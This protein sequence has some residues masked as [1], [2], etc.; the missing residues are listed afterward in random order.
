L[1]QHYTLARTERLAAIGEV[2]A[3]LAHEIRN[4]LAGIQMAFANFRREIQEP[5][6]VERLNMINAELKRLGLLLND[7]LDQSRHTPEVAVDFDVVSLI[8]DLATLTRYQLAEN[9]LLKIE[10]DQSLRLHLPESMLRQALLNLLLNAAGALEVQGG[11]IR[12]SVQSNENGLLI[13]V[14]DN[15]SGFPEEMLAYGIRP[16]RSSH[17]RGTG[18]GLAM[19]QRFVKNI[20]GSISLSNQQ[21]QGACVTMSLPK[22]CQLTL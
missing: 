22:A 10:A 12:I 21:P 11:E 20:G 14:I 18:L 15:G 13:Q 19:V 16:F 6:Q 2:A 1:E 7:M 3:E 9:I 8:Q 4:P 5:E 17:Q